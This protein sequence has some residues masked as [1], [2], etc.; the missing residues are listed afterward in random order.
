MRLRPDCIC[1]VP[2]P[3]LISEA[4]PPDS[5][6]VAAPPG[7][8]SIS[9][10]SKYGAPVNPVKRSQWTERRRPGIDRPVEEGFR[11]QA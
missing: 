7:G 4:P 3:D 2:P 1:E 11:W 5:I 10:A 9:G 8:V 6:Y